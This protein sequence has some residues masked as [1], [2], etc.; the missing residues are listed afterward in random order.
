MPSHD[1]EISLAPADLSRLLAD[2]RGFDKALYTATRKR[3][4]DAGE[5]AAQD[6]RRRLLSGHYKRDTG[7][8]RGLAKGT[9]VSVRASARTAG[10]T[11]TTT[12][13]KLP[14]AKQAMVKAFNR[15]TFRH[16]EWGH[17]DRWVNQKGRPYFGSVLY[18][19]RADMQSAME[20]ALA[21]AAR[22]IRGGVVS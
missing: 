12:G 7:L 15:P 22:T 20:Q 14:V 10:V 5:E 16:P 17:R 1:F 8:T 2:I 21:D 9:K 19:R 18:E 11:I 6:V 3:L 4:R 13:A